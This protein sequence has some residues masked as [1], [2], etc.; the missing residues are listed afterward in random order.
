MNEMLTKFLLIFFAGCITVGIT[1]LIESCENCSKR[2]QLTETEF[3]EEELRNIRIQLIKQQILKMLKMS[4]PPKVNISVVPKIIIEDLILSNPDKNIS[5]NDRSTDDQYEN[6]QNIIVL[7]EN[8]S[9]HRCHQKTPLSACFSFNFEQAKI[10]KESIISAYLWTFRNKQEPNNITYNIYNTDIDFAEK[11]NKKVL[12]YYVKEIK[13]GWYKSDITDILLYCS[14]NRQIFK[15]DCDK[16]NN[17]PISIDPDKRP[18]LVISIE[19]KRTKR[20]KRNID[21][22]SGS[23]TCCREKL[24]VS[25]REINW[26]NWIMQPSGY[27]A[28]YCRGN[29]LM[30]AGL[31]RYHHTTVKRDYLLKMKQRRINTNLSMCCS[32]SKLSSISMVYLN[33]KGLIIHENMPNMIVDACD[34]M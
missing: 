31:M 7:P 28:N 5:N 18:F 23:I 16:C 21:C 10:S 22:I 11:R 25:F 30:D 1:N 3:S 8:T 17:I 27:M 14:N 29:C 26:D 9:I 24:Y 19:E 32:P 4:R 33:E 6:I 20:M 15:I 34:C 2:K 13:P 12:K